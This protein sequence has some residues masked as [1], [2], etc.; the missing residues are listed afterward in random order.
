MQP[1]DILPDLKS[2]PKE[3]WRLFLFLVFTTTLIAAVSTVAFI[4]VR[5]NIRHNVQDTLTTIAEQKRQHLEQ[6]LSDMRDDANLFALGNASVA[7]MIERW[8]SDQQRDGRLEETIRERLAE[9]ANSQHYSLVAVFDAEG[10][11]VCVIGSSDVRRQGTAARK[12][13]QNTQSVFVDLHRES[14]G[15]IKFG[16]LSPIMPHGQTPNSALYVARD[17][18]VALYPLVGSWPLPTTTAETFLVRREDED[19]VFLSPL[20]HR[21][22]AEL[23]LRYSLT[24]PE[25]PAAA[26]AQGYHGVY[27]GRDYRGA[28]VLA[29]ASPVAGSPW[30]MVAKMDETEAFAAIR[31]TGWTILV[32]AA[33]ALILAYSSGYALWRRQVQRQQLA[34]LKALQA[35]EARFRRS[36]ERLNA[37]TQGAG[38]GIWEWDVE[39]QRLEW[40]DGMY[41]IYGLPAGSPVSYATWL[42]L[43]EP[44]VR[45]EQEAIRR[46]FAETDKDYHSHFRIKWPN[47][48]V[49]HL[50]SFGRV[51]PESIVKKTKACGG[52]ELGCHGTAASRGR[53][54]QKHSTLR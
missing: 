35:S 38:I 11:P 47:G 6:I 27:R 54:A 37:A 52:S 22:N 13:I 4:K 30:S 7:T 3:K 51:D 44:E 48:E 1:G 16:I 53:L 15:L 33:L 28:P 21:D 29:Y 17:A 31:S 41:R 8:V 42:E 23:N 34:A 26:A 36:A 5:D 2:T 18:P 45:E 32:L 49:R 43:L 40:D 12:A 25:L 50:R 46:K 9:I 39:A 20:R 10:H 14:D 24:T 19:V